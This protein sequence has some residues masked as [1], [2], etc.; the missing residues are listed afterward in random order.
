MHNL[1]LKR[2]YWSFE[3][4]NLLI[5]NCSLATGYLNIHDNFSSVSDSDFHDGLKVAIDDSSLGYMRA[6][7][8]SQ[9]I[10]KNSNITGRKEE[11]SSSFFVIH[12]SN[13]TISDSIFANNS[14]KFNSTEPTL[15]NASFNSN[16]T[17]VNCIVSGNTGY[18]SIIQVINQSFLRLIDSDISYNKI[19]NES[20]DPKRAEERSIVRINDSS[21]SVVS[22]NFTHNELVSP[23]I[24]GSVMFISYYSKIEYLE[25]CFFAKNRG[26][27][28]Y[29]LAFPGGKLNITNSYIAENYSP[30]SI[31]GTFSLRGISL[32]SGDYY[33]SNCTFV[34]NYADDG[35]GVFSRAGSTL[36]FKN[37]VFKE[38]RAFTAGGLDVMQALTHFENCSFIANE[39]I[40]HTGAVMGQSGA[41][42]VIHNCL[43][44]SNHALM[45][46]VHLALKFS[47]N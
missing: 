22:S 19:F 7:N 31:T 21:V 45:L 41:H 36:N 35:G 9:I 28:L 1:S 13:I 12:N 26:T 6:Q 8:V 3:S 18:A 43:F 24:G 17:F 20:M 29:T 47:Q 10:I 33:L 27:S 15:L 46:L 4:L 11:G 32:R 42:L 40:L 25:G 2:I 30:R 38:N 5:S 39:G 34:K 23:E 37:C 44:E 16:I 14:I